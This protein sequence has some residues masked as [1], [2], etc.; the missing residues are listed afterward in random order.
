[1]LR[2]FL[3][4]FSRKKKNAPKGSITHFPNHDNQVNEEALLM[5]LLKLRY[6][7]LELSKTL[8]KTTPSHMKLVDDDE[9]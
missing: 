6:E 4:F 7:L 8:E 3:S 5:S 1:M 2:K 9:S